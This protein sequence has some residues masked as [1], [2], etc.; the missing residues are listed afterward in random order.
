MKPKS[1]L[2]AEV[3]VAGAVDLRPPSI[4]PAPGPGA[5]FLVHLPEGATVAVPAGFDGEE[6]LVLL[7]VVREALR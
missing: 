2:L 3:Q 7:T 5:G 6:V 4:W 1:S